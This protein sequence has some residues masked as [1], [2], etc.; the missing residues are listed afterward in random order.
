VLLG[1]LGLAAACAA[2]SGD[3]D[4]GDDD[5]G[6][7]AA[8]TTGAGTGS[9]T[10]SQGGGA[11]TGT[12]GT[13]SDGGSVPA[14]PGCQPA[15]STA[16]DCDLGSAPYDPDNYTCSD[17]TCHY[18][19][20]NSDPECQSTGNFVCRDIGVTIPYCVMP[21]SSPADCSSGQLAYDADNYACPDGHCVYL[22]CHSDTECQDVLASYVCRD[23][24][25]GVS[26]CMP[27][28]SVPSDCDLSSLPY[29]AD[30]YICPNGGCIYT[31]CNSDT[32]CQVLGD[33]VC[34]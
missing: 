20:C 28:C 6:Q 11:G 18:Q 1:T 4:D 19:G 34:Q 2:S 5:D 10:T 30:N 27:S 25:S 26:Y 3:D 7:G 15:C 16:A 9:G 23:G 29:D 14:V 24:G 22:G 32:E 21:C 17:G 33:Y 13:G 8:G 31:G 12:T